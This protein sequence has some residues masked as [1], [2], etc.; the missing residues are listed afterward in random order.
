[1]NKTNDLAVLLNT[2]IKNSEEF[3]VYFKSL[4]L[5]K[6]HSELFE[7]EKELKT[8]QQAI[9]KERTKEDGDSYDLEV[10][11][12]KKME[13]FKTHPLIINYL[14]DKEDLSSLV[15][16]IQTYIQGLLD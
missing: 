15:S 3:K 8:L 7:L 2:E 6:K 16:Y 9:L 5:I 11:Y 13:E 10:S 1:M 4:Q 14:N 12:R